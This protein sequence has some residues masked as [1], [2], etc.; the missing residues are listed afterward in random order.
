MS[1]LN[2]ENL[3]AGYGKKTI[4]SEISLT[5]NEGQII[6]VLG[7]NGCGKSTLIKAVCNGITSSGS[8]V[9][10]GFNIKSL[11]EKELSK[12]CSYVPQRS[13]LSIDISVFDTVM[14]GFYPYL[15]LLE[16]PSQDMKNRVE[17]IITSVGLGNQINCN[18]M[19]LSEGQKRLCILARSLVGKNKLLLLD[20]PDGALDFSVRNHILQLVHERTK[21]IQGG[22][23]LTLHDVNLALANCDM[24]YLMKDGKIVGDLNPKTDALK[25]IECKLSDLYGKI[26]MLDYINDN[27]EKQII[28]VQA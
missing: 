13:G 9:I 8:I 23:L 12:I 10:D 7:A 25:D 2:I 3:S 5:V 16:S 11:S 15:K 4:I 14:M 17:E 22:V 27:N 18:Y 24:I 20:E 26:R 28:M 1:I 6:G 19:E 21:N